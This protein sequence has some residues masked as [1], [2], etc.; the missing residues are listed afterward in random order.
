MLYI[1][2]NNNIWNLYCAFFYINTDSRRTLS[3]C[4]EGSCVER[5]ISIDDCSDLGEWE[6]TTRW[7]R[8]K[9]KG[10]GDQ[11]K[12]DIGRKSERLKGKDVRYL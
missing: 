6:D 4:R 11:M 3:L 9:Q 7:R 2:F 5:E 8:E 10:Q 12:G 1:Y